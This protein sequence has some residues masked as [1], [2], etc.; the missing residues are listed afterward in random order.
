MKTRKKNVKRVR[1]PVV[2]AM[3]P[4]VGLSQTANRE[5][6]GL[7]SAPAM[8]QETVAEMDPDSRGVATGRCNRRRRERRPEFYTCHAVL[9]EKLNLLSV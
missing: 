6:F 2:A 7:S 4:P 5:A 9:Q 3:E 8:E 1:V